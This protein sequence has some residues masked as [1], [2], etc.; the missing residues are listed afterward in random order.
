MLKILKM[1]NNVI[2]KSK[3]SNSAYIK[4]DNF[5]YISP[6]TVPKGSSYVNASL[7]SKQQIKETTAFKKGARF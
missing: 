4:S 3:G 2:L 6:L 7:T 5:L 1:T